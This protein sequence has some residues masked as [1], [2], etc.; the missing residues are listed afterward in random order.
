MAIKIKQINK[1]DGKKTT[2]RGER[3]KEKVGRY[4]FIKKD[5]LRMIKPLHAL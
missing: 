5:F 4:E 1:R 2:T 3:I